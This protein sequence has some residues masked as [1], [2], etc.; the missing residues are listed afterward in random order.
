MSTTNRHWVRQAAI[1]GDVEE[2]RRELA[3]GHVIDEYDIHGMTLLHFLCASRPGG[4][5]LACFHGPARR[6]VRVR[7]GGPLR[8]LA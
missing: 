1:N 6:R 7:R 8:M 5:R 3:I 4:D 2:L